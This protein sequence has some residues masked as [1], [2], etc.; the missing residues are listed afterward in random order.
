M[1]HLRSVLNA[2]VVTLVLFVTGAVVIS[3][4]SAANFD[5]MTLPGNGTLRVSISTRPAGEYDPRWLMF[6]SG[7][8]DS[9]MLCDTGYCAARQWTTP[10]ER[11]GSIFDFTLG[12]NDGSVELSNDNEFSVVFDGSGEWTFT[13]RLA[14][15]VNPSH[16]DYT[17]RVTFQEGVPAPDPTP[18]PTPTTPLT[19]TVTP[20]ASELGA[21]FDVAGFTARLTDE[22]GKPW[23]GVFVSWRVISG[24]DIGLK[25]ADV[26]DGD[27][28]AS[29]AYSRATGSYTAPSSTDELVFWYEQINNGEPDQSEPQ[30]A[31]S[32]TF[33]AAT[34]RFSCPDNGHTGPV[35]LPKVDVEPPALL[36]AV[37]PFTIEYGNLPLTFTTGVARSGI[38]CT[39]TSNV[40]HLPVNVVFPV[41]GVPY[42]QHVA[43]SVA[44]ATLDFLPA[45]TADP[46]RCDFGVLKR[47]HNAIQN[48]IF[49]PPPGTND[50]LLN[51]RS[52]ASSHAVIA[53]W[54]NPGFAEYV[55]LGGVDKRV[56]AT[57]PLTYYVD[58][59]T[60]FGARDM[61]FDDLVQQVET[62]YHL[63]LIASLPIIDTMAVVQDPPARISV[64][65]AAGNT[66]GR[67]PDG[68]LATYDNA[69][70]AEIGDRSI[71]VIS[72]PAAGGYRVVAAG[73]AGSTYSVD[74]VIVNGGAS[75]PTVDSVRGTIGAG[76]T[77][78]SAFHVVDGAVTSSAAA[79]SGGGQSAA[80]G[81]TFAKPLVVKV[82]DAAGAPMPGRT[83]TFAVAAGSV[84][85]GGKGSVTAVTN[86]QGLATSPPVLAGS[87]V[88]GGRVSATVGTAGTSFAL[89]V[90]AAAD[91]SL[92]FGSVKA[93]RAGKNLRVTV[94]VTNSG[95]SAASA[96][97][98]V[99][100]L[101]KGVALI[102]AGGGR[103]SGA[104]LRFSTATIRVGGK[105]TYTF[106]VRPGRVTPRGAKL[107]AKVASAV[108][109]PRSTN[110]T[111]R[112]GAV[113]R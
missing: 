2:A 34:P 81:R 12:E 90:V 59:E 93:V 84:S 46:P 45:A 42:H 26:T 19:M 24:P 4:A 11:R 14:D 72:G 18:T 53:R 75:P 60:L 38:Y 92:R 96:V 101:P 16:F 40:G 82:T 13:R 56:F 7:S 23:T 113:K 27:G 112:S 80:V 74:F 105:V 111:A 52:N 32:W 64:T 68:S 85:F 106:T 83:V 22:A 15:G 108:A 10:Y 79:V 41:A 88:G 30:A 58:L 47:V 109:D 73:G 87:R 49:T 67:L 94:T 17:V 98:T 9:T 71:A 3:P 65:D 86:A 54:T 35:L 43:D 48:G 37:K 20:T 5:T 61:A 77:A 107:T 66:V 100:T 76:G 51:A 110:N 33:E 95:P 97:S 57:R 25:G 39:T 50:C 89:N 62:F 103:R 28:V 102:S 70:Y 29:I 104:T 6:R 78:T 69:G 8:D 91:V 63:T 31:A 21:A 44:T 55:T 1:T 99:V 36:H